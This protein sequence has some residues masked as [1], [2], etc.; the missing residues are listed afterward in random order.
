MENM[1]S[2]LIGEGINLITELNASEP[3]LFGD[4]M[5]L[6]QVIMNLSVNSMQAMEDGGMLVIQTDN[7]DLTEKDRQRNFEIDPGR[8][9][10]LKVRDTG[11]GIKDEI[12]QNIFEPFFTSRENGRGTGL[13]LSVVYGIIKQHNGIITVKSE[14]NQGTEF[15][16]YLKSENLGHIRKERTEKKKL[17]KNTGNGE[18]I[19]LVEDQHEVR[20]MVQ[21]VLTSH[22]FT[23]HTSESIGSAASLAD[24]LGYAIDLVFCDVILPDGNGLDLVEIL[25]EKN[26]AI[27]VLMSSGYANEK[28]HL[29]T[30]HDRGYLFLQKPYTEERL[31]TKVNNALQ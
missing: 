3:I 27:K 13:G 25:R 7:V 18:K 16:I 31:L 4:Q 28:A 21:H 14:V 5:Q 20:S 19:L 6:E 24:T 17:K 8:Y 26:R 11:T 12:L 1:V 10:V 23:V 9:I 30:I 29:D 15:N 2:R 22:G